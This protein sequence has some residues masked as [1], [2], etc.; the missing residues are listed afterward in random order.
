MKQKPNESVNQCLTWA[1]LGQR[2][3]QWQKNNRKSPRFIIFLFFRVEGK[4]TR[5]IRP[6]LL[7]R[8]IY[9]ISFW[10][11]T[12]CTH[13]PDWAHCRSR[14]S[15]SP[16]DHHPA[17][18]RGQRHPFQL[19]DSSDEQEEQHRWSRGVRISTGTGPRW[20]WR[21]S[22]VSAAVQRWRG[23]R[24]GMSP[25][26]L[27]QLFATGVLSC[28]TGS[29]LIVKRCNAHTHAQRHININVHSNQSD[30]RK[31]YFAEHIS[32]A[33]RGTSGTTMLPASKPSALHLIKPS[34]TG[35]CESLSLGTVSAL[36]DEEC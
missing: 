27:F 21:S 3:S 13:D 11:M 19:E 4:V 29:V 26:V 32:R 8:R 5:K 14:L 1:R 35:D 6:W 24:C 20:L 17:G 18:H 25:T 12:A 33:T 34:R 10:S 22:P 36:R 2:V 30:H 31:Y 7:L 15:L 23:S 9:L 16:D 28:D